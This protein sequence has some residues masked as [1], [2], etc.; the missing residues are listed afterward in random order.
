MR[1]AE[2]DLVVVL[3]MKNGGDVIWSLRYTGADVYDV[4]DLVSQDGESVRRRTGSQY[5]LIC[6][7]YAL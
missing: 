3:W 7:N 5:H 6:E 1:S 4:S 2:W